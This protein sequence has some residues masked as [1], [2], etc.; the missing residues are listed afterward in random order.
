MQVF[1]AVDP[2]VQIQWTHKDGDAVSTGTTFG[3][4]SPVARLP[5]SSTFRCR[6]TQ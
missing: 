4:A 1:A 3:Q 5:W 6:S 2:S